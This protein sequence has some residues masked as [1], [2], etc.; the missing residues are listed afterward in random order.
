MRDFKMEMIMS[1][2]EEGQIERIAKK[3]TKGEKLTEEES[4]FMKDKMAMNELAGLR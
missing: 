3:M 2:W 1:L 4:N